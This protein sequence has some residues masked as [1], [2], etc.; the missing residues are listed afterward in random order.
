MPIIVQKRLPR[1]RE[2]ILILLIFILSLIIGFI[3]VNEVRTMKNARPYFLLQDALAGMS[4]DHVLLDVQIMEKGEGYVLN[5]RGRM[6]GE[7]TLS[8][9]LSEYNL[10]IYLNRHG[11]LYVKDL[12][13]GTWT[14][15]GELKLDALKEF[16]IMPFDLLDHHP[17]HFKEAVFV[18][19]GDENEQVIKLTLPPN[20]F[21]PSL[22]SATQEE[23]YLECI[24]FIEEES[25][26]INRISFSL[27]DY[28]VKKELISR[29]FFFNEAQSLEK[30]D[31]ES[32]E[33]RQL[34]A[35]EEPLLTKVKHL[36]EQVIYIDEREGKL[37]PVQALLHYLGKNFSCRMSGS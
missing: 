10:E 18:S 13:S 22:I 23:V 7:K 20:P 11:E 9:E 29:T 35:F 33:I 36:Y 15:A 2:R 26:F 28:S 30:K 16:F 34:Q 1:N 8:G 12:I 32:K 14:D 21:I 27:Y 25:L 4:A 31:R 5:F 24:L 17:E 19:G 37:L 6:L 3:A